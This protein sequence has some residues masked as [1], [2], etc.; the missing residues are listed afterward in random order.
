MKKI[1][2]F[3]ALFFWQIPVY[4]AELHK[5][6]TV[7]CVINDQDQTLHFFINNDD[8]NEVVLKYTEMD[9]EY[10][11]YSSR[12]NYNIIEIN[13]HKDI[14]T[15]LLG[16]IKNYYNWYKKAVLKNRV[17]GKTISSI[18]LPFKYNEEPTAYNDSDILF[19]TIIDKKN[20]Y[21]LQFDFSPVYLKS[22]RKGE[23]A[24]VEFDNLIFDY[25][26]VI[27]LENA[28]DE[29]LIKTQQLIYK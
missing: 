28:L 11:N 6:I 3:I 2:L 17:I 19:S 10:N 1:I 24:K 8:D 5:Y 25:K 13:L 4:A 22:P 26:N 15:E 16:C 20:K 9:I 29:N 12:T 21:V 23:D 7:P 18:Q 27:K 14:R